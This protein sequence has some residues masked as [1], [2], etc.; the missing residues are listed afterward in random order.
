MNRTIQK[1]KSERGSVLVLSTAAMLGVLLA[2]GLGVDISHFYLAK[3]ELQ[4]AADAAA[5]AAASAIN[6]NP[7]GITEGARRARVA[8]NKYEFNKDAVQFTNDDDVLWAV[9]LDGPYLKTSAAATDGVADHI[10]FV[11][12]TTEESPVGIA[13]ASIVLGNNKNMTATSTAGLSVPLNSFCGFIPL[14]VLID[15]DLSLLVPGTVY[16][17]RAGSGSTVSPGDYQ[18]LAVAGPGGVDVGFGIG[19]G[20]DACA[21][22]GDTYVTDC[23]PGLTAG[24]VRTGINSRFDD[25]G[26]SQLDPMLEPPDTNIKENITWDDYNKYFGCGRPG[27]INCDSNYVTAPSHTGVDM[28]RVVLIPLVKV[29]EFDQGR[30]EVKFARFGAFFMR[31]KASNGS[32]GD[33]Q[34]EYI[35]DRLAIGKGKYDP[36]GGVGDPLLAVPVLY[37]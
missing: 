28:R 30:C 14:S 26:G 18:I 20:V 34:A 13:F 37:Q 17:I 31:T 35:E 32:G 25:Y 15:A 23:K 12:V 6:S 2:V 11:K 16:T 33:I 3:T 9:N 36:N 5:L 21:K 1:R 10:R 22:P 24:K 19:A 27:A 8:M 4:N 29:T 7:S